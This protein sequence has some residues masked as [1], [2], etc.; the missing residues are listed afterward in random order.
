MRTGGARQKKGST[1]YANG[2]RQLEGGVGCVLTT[3]EPFSAAITGFVHLSAAS[4]ENP[5][6]S[7]YNDDAGCRESTSLDGVPGRRAR[8]PPKP[9]T[10][11]LRSAPAQNALPAG[12]PVTTT[13][14]I[15]RSRLAWSSAATTAIAATAKGGV[16]LRV[17]WCFD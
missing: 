2:R 15:D 16:L 13:V 5:P 11:G 17:F 10:P 3:A 8:V 9:L 12:L 7:R 14:R 1:D 4:E 6:A